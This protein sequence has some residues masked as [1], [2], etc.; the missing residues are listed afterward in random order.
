[1]VQVQEGEQK[2]QQFAGLF[3]FYAMEKFYN[4]IL[5]SKE[6][7]NF[8]IGATRIDPKIRTERHL[9]EYYGNSKFTAKADDW[10][11]FF[12]I[13]CISFSQAL[14]IENHIKRMKSKNYILNLARYPEISLKLLEKYSI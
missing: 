3:C 6:L 5:Y 7:D 2:G 4:Y 13:E 12:E 9:L 1:M 8:Y 14:K 11:V 10:H